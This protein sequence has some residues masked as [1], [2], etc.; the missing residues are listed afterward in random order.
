MIVFAVGDEWIG[1]V[2]DSGFLHVLEPRQ[3]GGVGRR[4]QVVAGRE[5]LP[6]LHEGGAERLQVVGQL[7]GLVAVTGRTAALGSLRW[8]SRLP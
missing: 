4:K 7:L 1:A 2:V 6:E 8:F 3:R 5:E